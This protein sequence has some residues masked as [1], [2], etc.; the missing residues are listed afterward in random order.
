[1]ADVTTVS[2]VD[3]T[4]RPSSAFRNGEPVR[5]ECPPGASTGLAPCKSIRRFRLPRTHP[6]PAAALRL[7]SPDGGSLRLETIPLGQWPLMPEG[8]IVRFAPK[9]EVKANILG[10]RRRRGLPD[11]MPAALL[12]RSGSNCATAIPARRW[13]G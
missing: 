5:G 12:S 13:S 1:M 9:A 10:T 7:T 4:A 3:A 2:E 11:G 6:I 8:E